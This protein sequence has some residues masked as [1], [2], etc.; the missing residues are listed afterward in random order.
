MKYLFRNY[1]QGKSPSPGLLERYPALLVLRSLCY[2]PYV[3]VV[4]CFILDDVEII[5]QGSMIQ[6]LRG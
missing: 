6:A 4:I 1:G 5:F 2:L 3:T